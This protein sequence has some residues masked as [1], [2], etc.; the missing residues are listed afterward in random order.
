MDITISKMEEIGIEEL[1]KLQLDI[2][3]NVRDFLTL[4][5]F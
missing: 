3:I 1:K 5:L 2:L 4:S